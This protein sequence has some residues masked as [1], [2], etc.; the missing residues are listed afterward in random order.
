MIRVTG[1][2]SSLSVPAVDNATLEPE[3]RLIPVDDL[4][5]FVELSVTDK[6]HITLGT[7][8][9]M[10]LRRHVSLPHVSLPVL[11]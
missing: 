4:L 5:V 10:L 8:V 9:V 1:P 3:P 2:A 7:P 11:Q 6:V